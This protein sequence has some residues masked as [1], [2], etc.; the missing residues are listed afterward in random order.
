[1]MAATSK[2]VAMLLRRRAREQRLQFL[3]FHSVFINADTKNYEIYF[4][5]RLGLPGIGRITISETFGS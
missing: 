4:T 5:E 3:F 2:G 1:M